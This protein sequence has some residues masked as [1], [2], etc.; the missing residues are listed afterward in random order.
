MPVYSIGAD[1][2]IS[3]DPTVIEGEPEDN[4]ALRELF[5]EIEEVSGDTYEEVLG[6]V[7]IMG[8]NRARGTQQMHNTA[9]Q[10][11]QGGPRLHTREPKWLLNQILP[12]T[13]STAVNSLASTDVELKPQRPFRP[14]FYR[15]SSFHSGPYFAVT[16]YAIGQENQFVAAGSIPL[17]LFSEV[18]TNSGTA[19]Q[20]ANPGTSI[21]LTFTNLDT[22][23]A[24]RYLRSGFW[25]KTLLPG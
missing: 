12:C 11:Q 16:A 13:V 22:L 7:D 14:D 9:R 25:G 4:A 5:G 1:Y 17:D 3:G 2:Q 8:A 23:Q 20:T 21:T 15:A 10:H 19:G 24:S 6:A 18:S